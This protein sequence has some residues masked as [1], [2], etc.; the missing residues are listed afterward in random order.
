[1][2]L[3]DQEKRFP[4]SAHLQ[5]KCEEHTP[6]KVAII[7]KTDR[8]LLWCEPR[9]V[10]ALHSSWRSPSLKWPFFPPTQAQTQAPPALAMGRTLARA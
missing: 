3:G 1:M 2:S 4:D 6:N 5:K 10:A 9:F 7:E 8:F